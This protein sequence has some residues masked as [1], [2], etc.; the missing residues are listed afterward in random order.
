MVA[1]YL[2]LCTRR[3]SA[4]ARLFRRPRSTVV[5]AVASGTIT[6]PSSIAGAHGLEDISVRATPATATLDETRGTPASR[7]AVMRAEP[8]FYIALTSSLNRTSGCH[9]KIVH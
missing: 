5:A 9:V 1:P 4:C 6:A 7:K 2:F 8:G 3:P